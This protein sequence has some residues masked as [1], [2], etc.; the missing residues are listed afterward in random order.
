MLSKRFDTA[1]S[2]ALCEFTELI[3]VS[4][5]P[6]AVCAFDAE[7]RVIVPEPAAPVTDTFSIKLA[8]PSLVA[9]AMLIPVV[10]VP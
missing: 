3:A 8:V 10:L 6:I 2:D 7:F 5:N 4:I 9:T 1:P